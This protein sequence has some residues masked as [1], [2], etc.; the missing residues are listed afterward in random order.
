MRG[1]PW[2]TVPSSLRSEAPPGPGRNTSQFSHPRCT[3]WE[4]TPPV[5]VYLELWGRTVASNIWAMVMIWPKVFWSTHSIPKHF[6]P[7][8]IQMD[9]Y[10]VHDSKS[11][12]AEIYL[13]LLILFHLMWSCGNSYVT[14]MIWTTLY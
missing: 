3:M 13:V 12:S 7:V 14:G 5:G 4:L 9:L 10:T 11:N 2:R 6:G 8:P 1:G